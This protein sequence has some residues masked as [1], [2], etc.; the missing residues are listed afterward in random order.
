METNKIYNGD[1][2]ELIK[3]IED[4]SIDFAICDY[5]FNCQDGRKDYIEFIQIINDEIYRVLKENSVL[6]VINNPYNFYKTRN[7]FNN[8]THRD[9]IALIK[10]GVLRP[11]WHFGFQ[12]NYLMTFVKGKDN[13][14][15]WNGTKMNH[16]KSFLSDV[17]QY[18]NGFRGKGNMFHPQAI[19]LELTQKFIEIFSNKDDI[20]LDPFMGSGTTA[21]ACMKSNRK[22]IGFEIN[23]TYFNISIQRIMNEKR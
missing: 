14:V 6:L 23:Q 5:P 7:C 16:D 13:R 12:H 1:C 18:Q 11:A 19:P 9:S 8:F 22:F 4:N 21:I 20:V 3:N 10:R 2:I 15:K 17:I